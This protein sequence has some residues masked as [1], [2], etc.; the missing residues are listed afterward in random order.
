VYLIWKCVHGGVKATGPVWD[1]GLGLEW[2]LP[3]PAPYHSWVVA[4]SMSVIEHGAPP[5]EIHG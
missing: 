1:F 5:H 3:S 4:P 2:Q